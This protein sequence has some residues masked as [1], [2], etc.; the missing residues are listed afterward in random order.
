MDLNPG[1]KMLEES[2]FQDAVSFFTE[3]IEVLP[4]NKT[5]NICLGRAVGLGG[6][7][8]RAL[9]IFLETD[10]RYPNDYELLLNIGEA[11]LWN[12]QAENSLDIYE[13]LIS[14]DPNNYTANL[15]SA[16]CHF[17]LKNYEQALSFIDKAIAIDPTN[18]AAVNSKKYILLAIANGKKNKSDFEGSNLVLNEILEIY[19]NDA[20][21]LINIAINEI[22]LKSY[23][24]ADATL[25]KLLENNDEPIEVCLLLSHLSMLRHKESQ[26]IE[27]ATTAMQYAKQK[28]KG[29]LLRA[30]IQKVNALGAAKKFNEAHLLLDQLDMLFESS[31]QVDLAR[32][33]MKVWD[34]DAKKGLALY[35]EMDSSNY[36]YWMGKTEALMALGKTNEALS[37][38]DQ[39][40]LLNP[41]SH[42]AQMLRSLILSNQKAVVEWWANQSSDAGSN[43]ASELNFRIQLPKKEKHSAHL[44]GG[45]RTTD[46]SILNNAANQV[47]LFVGDRFQINHKLSLA[48]SLGLISQQTSLEER[49]IRY[50]STSNFRYQFAK[51][52]ALEMS[53]NRQSLEYSSDLI[54]SG[55]IENRFAL[56]Y[57][58]GKAKRPGLF[59]QISN[60]YLSDGNSSYNVFAS[61][62]Y[63]ITS[64]PVIKLG[65][66]VTHLSFQESKA[67]QY[68]SPE[69]YQM[70]ELFLHF[71]NVYDKDAKFRY[72]ALLALGKQRVETASFENT[73][74]IELELGYRFKGKYLL[75]ANYFTNTAANST[76]K[77]YSFERIGLKLVLPL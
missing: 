37:S 22:N 65:V 35:N 11:Y 41:N 29:S 45:I 12:D 24:K 74:R 30:S 56:N 46:N 13:D 77:A 18:N 70:A 9:K 3:V 73:S 44:T 10:K 8:E 62:F 39:A 2:K 60:T 23:K 72:S 7:A 26:A 52:Q 57:Q 5:A 42:D 4:E 36:D 17:S 75:S 55:L 38:L 54:E 68:F 69:S 25:Q 21:A 33:R 27:Y 20:Q 14:R 76:A 64:F 47:Q 66:N 67:L 53:F 51:H 71:G 48:A 40:L 15:G 16:N 58:Y 61:A 6:D 43:E 28:D 1:F 50:L 31:E 19:P 59:A 49:G 32:A 63:E 34:K